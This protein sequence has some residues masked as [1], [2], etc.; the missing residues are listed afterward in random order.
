MPPIVVAEGPLATH[1][2]VIWIIPT[3]QPAFWRLFCAAFLGLSE[4]LRVQEGEGST[5]VRVA[6]PAPGWVEEGQ[7]VTPPQLAHHN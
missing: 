7:P 2:K 4:S 5:W 6:L 3:F 1:T